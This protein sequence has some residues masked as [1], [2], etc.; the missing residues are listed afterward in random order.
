MKGKKNQFTKVDK[1]LYIQTKR[2]SQ[3]SKGNKKKVD[4]CNGEEKK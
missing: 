1:I 3:T 4:K 2:R